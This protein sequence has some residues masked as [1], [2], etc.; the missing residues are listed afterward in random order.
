MNAGSHFTMG[1]SCTIV[2]N[3]MAKQKKS[4]KYVYKVLKQQ[5]NCNCVKKPTLNIN[6]IS[7]IDVHRV[8]G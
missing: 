8:K 6:C 5:E 7:F 2:N 3:I 1:K 4:R